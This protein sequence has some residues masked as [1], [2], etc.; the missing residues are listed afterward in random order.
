[1]T[2]SQPA[3]RD[4]DRPSTVVASR[5]KQPRNTLA[6]LRVEAQLCP[7]VMMRV[8]GLIAQQ[9]I[10]PATIQFERRTRSVRFEIAVDGLSDHSAEILLEKVRM[11]VTVRNARFV[12]RRR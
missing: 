1:M 6:R 12:G 9:A 11:I 5:T 2:N 10:V 8:L 7:Q 3:V 4:A